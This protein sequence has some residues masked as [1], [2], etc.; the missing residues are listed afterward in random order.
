MV[1][2]LL[3]FHRICHVILHDS[4]ANRLPKR[5]SISGEMEICLKYMS[6]QRKLTSEEIGAL[7]AFVRQH[8]VEFYD[9]E[10][11]LV[12]HLANDIETQWQAETQVSFEQALHIAFKKFGVFGFMDV[13]E[14]Q[15]NKLSAMYYKESFRLLKQFF[16][17]PKVIFSIALALVIFLMLRVSE[18]NAT[19]NIID[20]LSG[21]G[22]LFVVFQLVRLFILRRKR[23][24]GK[25]LK[26]LL[27]QVLYH[28]EIWPYY[29]MFFWLFNF[30]L[31]ERKS[32]FA[33]IFQA[34]F[35]TLILLYIYILKATIIPQIKADRERQIQQLTRV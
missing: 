34:F 23:V 15:V 17:L 11:E 35:I 25:Q 14:Q 7:H 18:Q 5:T 31:G 19:I 28:L 30:N 4:L 8:Y 13:V 16:T 10:L 26:W 22:I 32:I 12:D 20:M 27:D 21:A 6:M 29:I 9:V 2:L 1:F 3:H 33:L 24:K